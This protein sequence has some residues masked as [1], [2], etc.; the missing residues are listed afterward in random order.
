MGWQDRLKRCLLKFA[1]NISISRAIADDLAVPSTI[2]GNPYREEIFFRMDN[3][4][5]DI[6]LVYLGR[7]VS[8]KGLDLLLRALVLLKNEG[9]TPHLTIAGVGPEEQALKA[10]TAELQIESQV[11][12][13]GPQTGEALARLLNRHRIM[14]VPSRW[15]EPFGIVALEGI[16]CGCAV[17][18]S[19]AGGLAEAI[20]PCGITFPNGNISAL[21][22]G[23][24]QLLV[25]DDLTDRLRAAAATHLPKFTARNVADSYLNLFRAA[26]G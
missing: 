19:E 24:R 17:I 13:A 18:G 11:Q 9:L 2:I 23:L 14:V 7:L 1:T 25:D 5:R 26:I 20:G 15:A 4:A 3:V 12:F 16:A 8:D 21:A 6:D 10:L 22:S